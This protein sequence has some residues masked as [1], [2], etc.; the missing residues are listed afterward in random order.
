MQSK[1]TLSSQEDEESAIQ[2]QVHLEFDDVI[3]HR[4][5]VSVYE[6]TT[7]DSCQ[8]KLVN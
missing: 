4:T 5:E 1:S 8:E 3:S 7:L 6:G 2:A